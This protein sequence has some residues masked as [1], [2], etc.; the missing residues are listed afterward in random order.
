MTRGGSRSLN[1]LYSGGNLECSISIGK[2]EKGDA[3]TFEDFTPEQLELLRGHKGERGE[4]FVYEDFTPEQLEQLKGAKGDK[5]DMG[6]KVEF[7]KSETHIQYKYTSDSNWI[8]L[9]PLNDLKTEETVINSL[10][11]QI[12]ILTE[13]VIALEE[14]VPKP[15]EIGDIPTFMGIVTPFKNIKDITQDLLN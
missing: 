4:P 3:F 13:R 11:E 10:L 15:P 12:Q 9:V 1:S 2:G 14:N 5:G 8:D 7:N 6:E